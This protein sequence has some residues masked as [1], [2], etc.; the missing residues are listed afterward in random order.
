MKLPTGASKIE[1]AIFAP[2]YYAVTVPIGT[3][4][5]KLNSRVTVTSC[6]LVLLDVLLNKSGTLQARI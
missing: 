3:T 1:G 4:P 2:T 6:G 5:Q